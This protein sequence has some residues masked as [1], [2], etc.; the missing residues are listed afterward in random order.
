MWVNTARQ[1]ER[2]K[3]RALA[4]PDARKH[5]TERF[6]ALRSRLGQMS[7]STIT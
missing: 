6:C 1:N 3:L 7:V 5:G 4:Y 2:G